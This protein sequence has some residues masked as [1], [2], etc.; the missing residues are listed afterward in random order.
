MTPLPQTTQAASASTESPARPVSRADINRA[1]ADHSTGPNSEIGKSRSSQNAFKHGLYSKK[2]VIHGE[3]PAELDRLK[4]DLRAEHQPVNETESIL[5]NEMAEQFWRLRRTRELETRAFTV[6][7]LDIWIESGI[8]PLIQRTMAAA[9]RGFHKALAALRKLQ[10]SRGFVPSKAVQ[11]AA[12]PAQSSGF[13]PS[14]PSEQDM[15]TEGNLLR[16]ELEKLERRVE[17][18]RAAQNSAPVDL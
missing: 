16:I 15:D 6:E 18:R 17:E 12:Q 2:L 1:N 5:V 4:D 9:E 11:P 13:V 10:D 14:F 3:D 8:L 7:N